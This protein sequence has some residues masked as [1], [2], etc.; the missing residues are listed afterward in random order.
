[1]LYK[2]F[3]GWNS[4]FF[5]KHLES[6]THGIKH[7]SVQFA[8][9]ALKVLQSLPKEYTTV[10]PFVFKS[11][12]AYVLRLPKKKDMVLIGISLIWYHTQLKRQTNASS[13]KKNVAQSNSKILAK[14]VNSEVVVIAI[15][16]YYCIPNCMNYG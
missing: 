8:H 10:H 6:K 12:D 2:K 13:C 1:M 7:C 9:A 4:K 3:L 5:N 16:V 11:T 14:T 15:S